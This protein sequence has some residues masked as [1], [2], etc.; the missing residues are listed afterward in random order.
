VLLL[1]LFLHIAGKLRSMHQSKKPFPVL[2]RL[3]LMR[4]DGEKRSG[5]QEFKV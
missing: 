3:F 4:W 2:E 5:A 1:A